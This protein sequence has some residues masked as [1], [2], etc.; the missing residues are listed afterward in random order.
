MARCAYVCALEG[1]GLPGAG[2]LGVFVDIV[3]AALAAVDFA[4]PRDYLIVMLFCADG[5]ERALAP[6]DK[7]EW[8]RNREDSA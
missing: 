7:T 2:I 5:G 4:C 1:H 8:Q 6:Q 3:V